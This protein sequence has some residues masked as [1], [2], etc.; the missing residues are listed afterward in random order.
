MFQYKCKSLSRV[1]SF[2]EDDHGSTYIPIAKPSAGFSADNRFFG[3]EKEKFFLVKRPKYFDKFGEFN[4]EQIKH[5]NTAQE[6]SYR[7]ECERWNLV[8]PNNKAYLFTED[9]LR[10]VLP[11]L[12]GENLSEC[13]SDNQLIRCKQL[14]SVA[15]AIQKFHKLGFTYTD[16]NLDNILIEENSEGDFKAYLIDF[17]DLDTIKDHMGAKQELFI[18]SQLVPDADW[19]L[20]LD[21]SEKLIDYLLD[22]IKQL[23]SSFQQKC[24]V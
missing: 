9:E 2:I 1:Q 3:R 13:L 8:Y 5:I 10:L 23:E 20:K 6:A 16:F 4:Q 22:K 24:N 14:L 7:L 15:Y 12:P 11:C 17:N 18:I 21:S 19:H